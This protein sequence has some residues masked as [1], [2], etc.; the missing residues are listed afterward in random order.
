MGRST[1]FRF[2]GGA[3]TY[4]G[5]ALLAFLITVLTLGICTPFAIVLRQ[6]WRAKHTYVHGR[7]LVF[8]GGAFQ[9]F[10]LWIKWFLLIVVTLGI[11]GLWVAPRIQKWIVENTDFEV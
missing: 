5:T 7:R 10:G 2:D 9:L 11:Y 8:V 3:A 6:R 4:I 1:S